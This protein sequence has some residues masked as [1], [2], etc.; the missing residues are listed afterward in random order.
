VRSLWLGFSGDLM[1]SDTQGSSDPSSPGLG[2]RYLLFYLTS[3][4]L[5]GIG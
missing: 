4:D 2:T 5:Q 1:F 3:D